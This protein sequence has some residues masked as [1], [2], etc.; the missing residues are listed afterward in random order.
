MARSRRSFT[1]R[2]ATLVLLLWVAFDVGAHGFITSDFAPA[3][4]GAPATLVALD[5][6]GPAAAAAHD[7]CFCNGIFE[8]AI[9]PAPAETLAPTGAIVP[10]VVSQAPRADGHPLDRPPQL[11]A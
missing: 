4:A 7:H 10:D 2:L 8:G 9:A 1:I 11:I 3:S 5:G 6:H